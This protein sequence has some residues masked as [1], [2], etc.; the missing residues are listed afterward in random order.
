[1]AVSLD[2]SAAASHPRGRIASAFVWLGVLALGVLMIA[3][4]VY[5]RGKAAATRAEVVREGRMDRWW[6]YRLTKQRRDGTFFICFGAFPAALGTFG[7]ATTVIAGR[8]VSPR[9]GVS[10]LLFA[11]L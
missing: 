3:G 9:G 2:I 6:E 1:M 8:A 10:R 7:F 4:G 11:R 5:T